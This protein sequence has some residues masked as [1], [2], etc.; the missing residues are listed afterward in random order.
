MTG[1]AKKTTLPQFSLTEVAEGPGENIIQV[2][3]PAENGGKFTYFTT[4]VVDPTT[5]KRRDGKPKWAPDTFPLFPVVLNADGSPWPEAN[6]WVIAMLEGK[7]DPNML[8]YAT[9]ADDL[10]A[11]RR[12]I[13]EEQIDWL[14]FPA[15]KL[16]RPTYR[17]NASLRLSVE[18]AEISSAVAKRR[19][20]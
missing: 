11:F 4:R 10:A 9:I 14:S 12:Y 6:L 18:A 13:D 17:Y 7:V 2:D 8:S 1:A 5:G 15:H 16:R 19:M 3:L 20:V